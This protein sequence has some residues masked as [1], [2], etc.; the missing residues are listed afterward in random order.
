[1]LSL[2]HNAAG[3]DREEAVARGRPASRIADTEKHL[4]IGFRHVKF[5]N[6]WTDDCRVVAVVTGI[7]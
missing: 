4:W 1:M 2:G 6:H 3:A 7:D 5:P